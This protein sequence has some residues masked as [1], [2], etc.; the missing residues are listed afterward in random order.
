MSFSILQGSSQSI[1]IGTNVRIQLYYLQ[2]FA[3][4][5]SRGPQSGC[6]CP[7]RSLLNTFSYIFYTITACSSI[8]ATQNVSLNSLT[9][10]A[11]P[12]ALFG[13]SE[14]FTVLIHSPVF[15][16]SS[17]HTASGLITTENEPNGPYCSF[18]FGNMPFVLFVSHVPHPCVRF[19]IFPTLFF[20]ISMM[21]MASSPSDGIPTFFIGSCPFSRIHFV[22][23]GIA[24]RGSLE[25][26]LTPV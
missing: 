16:L 12:M 19:P 9:R 3:S 11:D 15:P 14:S 5:F 7:M 8:P 4:D 1:L 10:S 20:T 2:Q 25:S 18:A 17:L 13:L 22:Y 21:F 24:I 26:N 6:I 23:S